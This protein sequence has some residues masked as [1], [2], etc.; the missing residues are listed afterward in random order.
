MHR[1]S[2][3]RLAAI[4]ALGLAAATGCS[5]SGG[6]RGAP[7]PTP[8]RGSTSAASPTPSARR[9]PA[10]LPAS[11]VALGDSITRGMNACPNT[12]GECPE[13]SWSTG[14]ALA[15]HYER[16]LA[17]RPGATATNLA[18][19]GATVADLAAQAR[20]AVALRPG[21]VTIL[22]G[23]NDACAGTEADMTSVAAFRTRLDAALAILRRGAPTAKVLV[24]SVPDL[25]R[26]WEVG[27]GDQRAVAG[28]GLFGICQ[29]M[30]ADPAST[31]PADVARR[32]RVRARA[33]AYNAQ[34][35]AACAAYGGNCRYDHGAAFGVRFTAA[36]V[37]PIDWFHPSA[38]GQAELARVTDAAGYAW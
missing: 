19:S 21:Y 30:L 33:M 23:A 22:I 1:Q 24:A 10:T 25:Y 29:T 5:G 8:D 9:D 20:S 16:I 14:T 3:V 34:L 4:L 12:F 28:W 2:R 36:D 35:G 15:S 38:A 6:G 13:E 11:V 32:E 31:A 7:A 18:Q 17:G 27:H 26:L 37:S